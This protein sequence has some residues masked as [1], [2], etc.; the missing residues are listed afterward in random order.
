[1][2]TSTGRVTGATSLAGIVSALLN[3]SAWS[4]DW[5]IICIRGSASITPALRLLTWQSMRLGSVMI[6]R[7]V[8]LIAT[9]IPIA[10][11]ALLVFISSMG[12]AWM[13]AP[14]TCTTLGKMPPASPALPSVPPASPHHATSAYKPIISTM[15][16]A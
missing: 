11:S 7:G 16:P 12:N 8:A 14:S 2:R 3:S 6:V 5:P 4:A 9:P 1:M 10:S 15:A 13:Y